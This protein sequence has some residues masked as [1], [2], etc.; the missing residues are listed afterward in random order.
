MLATISM[1]LFYCCKK[2]FTDTNAVTIRGGICHAIHMQKPTTNTWK[3]MIKK[4][5]SH[6]KHLNPWDVNGLY[7]QAMFQ[8]LPLGNFKWVKKHCKNLMKNYKEDSYIRYF[9]EV[10]VQCPIKLHEF[11][12]D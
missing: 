1:K 9:L 8:K 5:S 4:D 7:G 12:G 11:H 10:V 3:F 2:V 6:L